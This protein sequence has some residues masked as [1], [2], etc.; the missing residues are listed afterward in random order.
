MFV[1]DDATPPATYVVY[2]NKARGDLLR[3]TR[4]STDGGIRGRINSIGASVQRRFGE[5]MI[6]QSADTLLGAMKTQLER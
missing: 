5:Q 4:A 6:R 1:R 3:G 2:S